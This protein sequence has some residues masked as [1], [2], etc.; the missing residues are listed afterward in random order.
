MSE[1]PFGLV[2]DAMRLTPGPN[3]LLRFDMGVKPDILE[4]LCCFLLGPLL[5]LHFLFR[6]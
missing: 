2:I 3:F 5:S 4:G 1:L 6:L